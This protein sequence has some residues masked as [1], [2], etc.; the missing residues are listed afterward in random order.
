MP[1]PVIAA[2][3]TNERSFAETLRKVLIVV[4]AAGIN[5]GVGTLAAQQS[6][7]MVPM[8]ADAN[9][10]KYALVVVDAQ[11]DFWTDTEAATAPAMLDHL[12]QLL[13]FARTAGR[14]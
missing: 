14:T 10:N 8:N 3:R 13:G 4:A 1:A 11:H 5:C 7:E 2:R 6:A 12:E 9:W